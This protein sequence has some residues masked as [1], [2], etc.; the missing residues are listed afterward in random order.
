MLADAAERGWLDFD[1]QVQRLLA[2]TNFRASPEVI[3]AVGR[4]LR[5]H[6]PR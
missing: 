3:A 1:L 2:E 6:A 5:R 4:L